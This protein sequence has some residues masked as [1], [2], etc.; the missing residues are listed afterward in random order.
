MDLTMIDVTDIE[1]ASTGDEVALIG[2]QGECEITA[3]EV[4][5]QSGTISY[6]VTC[7]ISERVPRVFKE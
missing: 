6:E 7:S 4:A 2:R 3:E 5:A 1:G